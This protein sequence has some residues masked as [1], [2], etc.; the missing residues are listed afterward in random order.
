M[1]IYF[2]VEE[3]PL[4]AI[5]RKG[6]IRNVKTGYPMKT[7]L[8]AGYA[9]VALRKD[10]RQSQISIHRLLAMVFVDNPDPTTNIVVN[11][12]D[13]DKSNNAIDN[14]EWVTHQE[15]CAHA[16]EMGLTNPVKGREVDKIDPATGHVC[17]TFKSIREAAKSVDITHSG[18]DRAIRTGGKCKGFKWA[19][20]AIVCD[21]K[22]E[23][24]MPLHMCDGCQLKPGMYSVS[25]YGRVKTNT[26][27]YIL[28]AQ[29]IKGYLRITLVAE[30]GK[31]TFG[32]HRLVAQLFI[33]AK[34]DSALLDVD[35][36]DGDKTNNH[37]SNLQY[38]TRDEHGAKTS[39]KKVVQ[40]GLDGSTI[41]TYLSC[42]QAAKAINGLA[43]GVSRAASGER[44]TY[45][46][47]TWKYVD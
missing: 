2:V 1:S 26:S 14:L 24:W 25:N 6:E 5:S 18:V 30:D 35:H 42:G 19:F 36:K 12:K 22:D 13:G 37:A 23:V 17:A 46:G 34:K 47:F 27:G 20:S 15:N 43:P 3:F 31:K 32:V 44:K 10:G 38:L 21:E 41:A 28:K 7:R 29:E 33:P 9:V 4:Y 11:H 16:V 45:K 8:D 39:G 40:S